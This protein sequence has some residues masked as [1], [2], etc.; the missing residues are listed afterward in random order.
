MVSGNSRLLA[1]VRR[2]AAREDGQSLVEF[3]II[4]PLLLLM[5]LVFIQLILIGGVALAVNQAAASCARYASVN[6]NFDQSA[7]NTFLQSTASPLISDKYLAALTLTPGGVPRTTGTQLTVTV[8]YDLS[9][10]LVL[11]SSFM[12]IAFPTTIAITSTMPSE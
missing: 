8:S 2:Y 7:V 9:G 1:A 4:L 3:A 11:G 5:T 6:P 10:K 12:G